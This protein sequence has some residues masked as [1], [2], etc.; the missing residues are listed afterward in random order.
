MCV[1]VTALLAAAYAFAARSQNGE[2]YP[3]AT[4]R[5]MES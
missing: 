1:E 3:R 4:S 5:M 2:L